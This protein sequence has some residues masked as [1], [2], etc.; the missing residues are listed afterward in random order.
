MTDLN[1]SQYEPDPEFEPEQEAG[2]PVASMVDEA[3]RALKEAEPDA[4]LVLPRVVRRV[5]KAEWALPALRLQIPHRKSWLISKYELL[6][7]VDWDELSLQPGS[8]LPDTAILL[9]RP[10]DKNLETMGVA[11]LKLQ[12]WRLLFHSKIHLAFDALR[13]SKKLTRADFRERINRLGQVEFD[14][15]HTVLR[16][17]NF[18]RAET[19]LDEVYVEFAALY[20][21]LRFFTP[22]SLSSYFPAFEDFSA[23]DELLAGDVDIEKLFY[24]TRLA[25]ALN[26]L[27]VTLDE[28]D[29]TTDELDHLTGHHGDQ[30]ATSSP[31]TAS[32]ENE[33]GQDFPQ[34]DQQIIRELKANATP[35]LRTFS[36]L[37]RKADR[38]F[39][40]GNAVGA[41]LHQMRAAQFATPEL[42]HEAASGALTDMQ[43][44]VKRLQE[45]LRFDNVA[46]RAWYTTL[47]ALLQHANQ[48]FWHA[49]KKLLYDLQKVCVDHER[50]IHRVDL[51]S[52][53]ASFGKRPLSRPLPNQREVLMSKHLRS[54]T[55]RLVAARLSG[56]ERR[57]LS[58]L[59]HAA[60]ESAEHQMRS[61]LRPLAAETLKEVGLTPRN[62]P[63]MIAVR[64]MT[65]EL[66]DRVAVR[67]FFTMGD[68]RDTLSRS[69]LKLSDLSGPMEFFA[70]DKLLK[71]DR[72][73]SRTMDGVYQRGDIYL[74]WL[75][76]LSAASFGTL[77]GR[78]LT[79]FITI[80]YGS[81][82]I[83]YAAVVHILEKLNPADVEEDGTPAPGGDAETDQDGSPTSSPTDK[84]TIDEIGVKEP[85][86]QQ[87]PKADDSENEPAPAATD[88]PSPDSGPDEVTPAE[89]P[90]IPEE[91]PEA[92][93]NER[94]PAKLSTTG[95]STG[96]ETELQ[97]TT[98]QPANSPH[99]D[100]F[101]PVVLAL[102][103]LLL[104]IIH[105]AP[106]RRFLA[107]IFTHLF[108]VLRTVLYEW[109]ARFF[110]QPLVRK[111][112]RSRAAKL[113]RKFILGPLIPTFVICW[114]LPWQYP[115]LDEQ[116]WINWLIVLA[117]M[118]II[119]NSR[120]GRDV[121]ELSAE[122]VH[123]TLYRIRV[124]IFVALFDLIME[125]F[126]RML[127][128]F[129][130]GLYAVDEW[131]RFKSGE[132]TLSLALKAI[133]GV[134]WSVV[135]FV[136]RFC[137]NLL[138]EPQINPIK[139]F[140]V[141]TVSH[142]ILIPIGLP[143]GPLSSLLAPIA[144]SWADWIAGTTTLLMPGVFGF[145]V[146]ELKSNWLL[147]EANRGENLKPVLVGSHG[148]TFI[149]LMKPG[150]HS[151][152]L[153]KLFSRLRRVD[154]KR[155][156]ASEHSLA[157][158]RYLDQL[159]HVHTDIARFIDREFLELLRDTPQ[160]KQNDLRIERI[161]LASNNV[162]VE[163]ACRSLSDEPLVLVFEEQSGWLVANAQQSGWV[164]KLDD[165]QRETLLTAL[166]G[167]YRI[168]GVDLVR[169]QVAATF[170]PRTIPY[171]INEE[172]LVVWPAGFKAEAIYNLH[173]LHTIRPYPRAVA[174]DQDLPSVTPD[175]LIFAETN[176][177]WDV[178]AEQWDDSVQ[179]K[180]PVLPENIRWTWSDR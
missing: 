9:A 24:A 142:K 140:P 77:I 71:A 117:A 29:E 73:L 151:G 178:W 90:E 143:G 48:G 113:T 89:R 152:T 123:S 40:R 84:K 159:Q 175:A 20:S 106:F 118:S 13:D 176:L 146:W 46:A 33:S 27:E 76:R 158:S 119:I 56:N 97:S 170:A 28:P 132:T 17:E 19:P 101:V 15:I 95:E 25:G 44:L 39:A 155:E 131:L 52:W 166:I 55:R 173:H 91:Q 7:H 149:R 74:R 43:R 16:R 111:I 45:A 114:I 120:V 51:L 86:E 78:F 104:L 88:P 160:W 130:R 70:G 62:V 69:N 110:R 3:I 75:Q 139:H 61:R 87:Q 41:A 154:R 105:V 127:G 50:E 144:G 180:R 136:L 12:T 145:L 72:Q 94:P 138:I 6:R 85:E 8:D 179:E 79:R 54:A 64:K 153:P 128:W 1:D 59:L 58:R 100:H 49:D 22:H 26:P 93:L 102:G 83:T 53:G 81:A 147:Y 96:S 65:E 103:T 63:Q 42:I 67:G 68:L 141:V 31:P 34:L 80:P 14:E 66:L 174:R 36:R 32:D 133:L 21:E 121:E 116:S 122:W 2:S 156:S 60:A 165:E 18:I 171:D 4:F 172:G 177:S 124:H 38:E 92:I 107:Q 11:Q 129:E 112:F 169:E 134:V 82:Y 57:D 35:N 98:L 126:K 115:Q 150:F 164:G 5:I 135:T 23:V 125:S 108:S 47:V 37:I 161:R 167:L 109:P 137:V 162:R 168:A 163:L 99:P 148:E 10:D 157:R 30:F